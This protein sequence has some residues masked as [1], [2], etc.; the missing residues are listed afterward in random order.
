MENWG[1]ILYNNITYSL[2]VTIFI[3]SIIIISK[4]KCAVTLV[5]VIVLGL[6][7]TNA[8]NWIVP[9][10]ILVLSFYLTNGRKD[11]LET[12]YTC[13]TVIFLLW[14]F[15]VTTSSIIMLITPN[16][17]STSE[18]NLIIGAVLLLA[19]LFIKVKSHLIEWY[20]RLENKRYVIALEL[21]ILTFFSFVLPQYYTAIATEG[22]RMWAIF[23]LSLMAVLVIVALFVNRIKDLEYQHRNLTFQVEQ[24]NFYAAQVESQFVRV[25]TLKHYYIKLYESLL[26]FI[27]DGDMKGLRIYFEK[28]ISPIYHK[29]LKETPQLSNIKND[30]IRNL[31][32]STE[33]QASAMEKLSL[34]M[35]ISGK[36]CLPDN[37][38]LDI[39]EIMCNLLDNALREVSFQENSLLRVWLHQE[40]KQLSIQIA[41]SLSSNLDIGQMYILRGDELGYGL[42][43]VR[44]IVYKYPQI[45]HYTYKHG[46]HLGK[47]ILVQQ[48]KIQMDI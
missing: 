40:K 34:D 42:K 19:T 24:Q 9:I 14:A 43:R 23:P 28:N 2:A 33:G 22:I 38:A 12:F 30:L 4:L 16:L 18:F 25:V 5:L 37:M 6:L 20:T 41:N 11:K 32:D 3:S 7:L 21:V 45:E 27:R 29:Q 15:I 46:L 10:N 47:E 8:P 31:L 44:E 1:I 35:S 17:Y 26:P 48:I 13:V 39:F 36:I